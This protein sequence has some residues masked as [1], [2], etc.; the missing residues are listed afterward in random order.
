MSNSF[1]NWLDYVYIGCTFIFCIS[2]F[3]RGFTKDFF[4]T[5]AWFVSGF[6]SAQVYVPIQR[7]I[8]Q[9]FEIPFLFA[10]TIAIGSSYI[11]ILMI[12]FAIIGFL[13]RKVKNTDILSGV[14]RAFGALLGFVRGMLVAIAIGF[15]ILILNVQDSQYECIEQSKL[16]PYILFIA[17]DLMPEVSQLAKLGKEKLGLNQLMEGRILSKKKL[18][19]DEVNG[20]DQNEN[21]SELGENLPSVNELMNDIA[22]H[23]SGNGNADKEKLENIKNRVQQRRHRNFQKSER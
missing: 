10:K 7:L 20:L 11:F 8:L 3:I 2:G 5:C 22:N 19:E 1:F 18:S 13:S 23:L 12:L 21:L 14:D 9:N 16:T 6:I 17:H 4:S 15:G